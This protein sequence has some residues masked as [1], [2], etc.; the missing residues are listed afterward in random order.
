MAG[1]S[2]N[3][4]PRVVYN[5]TNPALSY[6]QLKGRALVAV[7]T[8]QSFGAGPQSV[9][10]SAFQV[11]ARAAVM[12]IN[13]ATSTAGAAT[14]NTLLGRIVTESLSTAAG[15][16]YTMTLTNS[17]IAANSIVEAQIFSLTNVVPG[18]AVTSI[19]PAA[20]SCVIVCTNTSATALSGT[21][22]IVFD[23]TPAGG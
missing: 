13:T 11:A 10:A 8:G 22:C 16:T 7:D 5:A 19:T 15:A 9:A 12:S 21:M 23:V 18:M 3:G 4:L 2:T 6:P 17:A 14:L 20:G 1:V